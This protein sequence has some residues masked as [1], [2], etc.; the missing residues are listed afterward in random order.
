MTRFWHGPRREF[1]VWTTQEQ[2]S[3]AHEGNNIHTQ[4]RKEYLCHVILFWA[5]L[6][7]V[8]NSFWTLESFV[9]LN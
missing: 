3:G 8:E 2:R 9:R 1:I 5:D 4:H 7:E 6:D